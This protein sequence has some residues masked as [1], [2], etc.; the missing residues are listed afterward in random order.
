MLPRVVVG[1]AGG[2]A[3]GKST[4][5]SALAAALQRLHQRQVLI[6]TTDRYMHNDRS[7]GPTFFSQATGTH[8]FD[9]NHPDAIAWN[10]VLRDLDD[11]LQ[12]TDGPEVILVEGHLLLHEPTVRARLDIRFFVELDADER[13]LRRLLRDMQGGRANRDPNFIATYYRESA[14]VGHTRYIEP[15]R[16][17]ADL[18]V[19]G[20]AVW[21]RIEP[22]LVAI[23]EDQLAHATPANQSAD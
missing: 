11:L 14:R 16:V 13:A 9:A 19:R 12:Q 17:H 8:M 21:E 6:L 7:F 10:H 3:S 22:F 15:S 18:I 4:L 1:I 5:A 20:D 2:S 23:I